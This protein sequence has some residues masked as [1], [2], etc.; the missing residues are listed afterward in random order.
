MST[1]EQQNPYPDREHITD[2]DLV[3]DE[4]KS[5]AAAERYNQDR[6]HIFRARVLGQIARQELDPY[7]MTWQVWKLGE[8][9]PDEHSDPHFTDVA[10]LAT[11]VNNPDE[12]G[13]EVWTPSIRI[14][15]SEWFKMPYGMEYLTNDVSVDDDGDAAQLVDSFMQLPGDGDPDETDGNLLDRNQ[16]TVKSSAPLVGV[17]PNGQIMLRNFTQYPI[18]HNYNTDQHTAPVYPWGIFR[19]FSDH[20]DA[21]DRAYEIFESVERLDPDFKG[22][23]IRPTE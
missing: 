9:T 3:A 8:T 4:Q 14:V 21:L 11:V 22:Q 10:L 2:D 15:R 18:M 12:K 13:S 19:N 5:T 23:L 6:L 20:S 7:N 16:L 17:Y 1:A